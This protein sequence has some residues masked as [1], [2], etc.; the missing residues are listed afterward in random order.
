ME[1]RVGWKPRPPGQERCLLQLQTSFTG[2]AQSGLASC[3][4]EPQRQCEG[5]AALKEQRAALEVSKLK[6]A[7][8][9]VQQREDVW[10]YLC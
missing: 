5:A 8:P 9:W 7:S 2:V 4:W 1:T 10:G 3:C 6:Q